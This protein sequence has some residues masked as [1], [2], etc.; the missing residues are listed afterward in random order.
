MFAPSLE[1]SEQPKADLIIEPYIFKGTFSQ[2]GSFIDPKTL[3][4]LGVSQITPEYTATGVL[5]IPGE[6]NIKFDRE[7]LGTTWLFEQNK[8]KYKLTLDSVNWLN[9]S[10]SVSVV[11]AN[12]LDLIPNK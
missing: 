7:S 10:F 11:E 1:D 9:N 6:N 8:K 5:H 12:N 4:T 3:V 2:G